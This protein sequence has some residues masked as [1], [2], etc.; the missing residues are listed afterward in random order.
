[1]SMASVCRFALD[2]WNLMD[3]F[4]FYRLGEASLVCSARPPQTLRMQRRV[5]ELVDI[6]KGWEDVL[7]VIPGM[8]NL[9]L[10]FDPVST[11]VVALEQRFQYA[12][13]QTVSSSASI[14]KIIWIPVSYGGADGSDL[15]ALAD[16]AGM[17]PREVIQLHSS[18]DYLVY[19]TGFQAGFAYLG[20][21]D[22]RLHMPRRA[23]PRISVPAGSVAIGG[24]LT[25]IYPQA[26]PGGWN[27][28]GR[29]HQQ[30][31]DARKQPPAL[32]QAGDIVRF[33]PTTNLDDAPIH[34]TSSFG[35]G[36]L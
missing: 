34:I 16:S 35:I 8:N 14:G 31:F 30:L 1:M 11:D 25:G 12:A 23:D 7:E 24:A 36:I 29:C 10:I 5:W 2:G 9:T 20:D 28:I 13:Q 3:F 4:S 32:L 19:F 18:I 15:E 26:S 21:L 33:I 17:T 6:V 27:L 22:P